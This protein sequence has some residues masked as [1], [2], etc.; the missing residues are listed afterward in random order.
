MN[1]TCVDSVCASEPTTYY[2]TNTTTAYLYELW[3][4]SICICRVRTG[5]EKRVHLYSC[6]IILCTAH[7]AR[8]HCRNNNTFGSATESDQT[9]RGRNRSQES[10]AIPRPE[11]SKICR[12]GTFSQS[13]WL[14]FGKSAG[15]ERG[16][17]TFSNGNKCFLRGNFTDTR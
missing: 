12:R 15:E 10:R 14:L 1:K 3:C 9:E 17:R 13:K 8:C 6:N 11:R 16:R 4:G 7:R 2:N 5:Q